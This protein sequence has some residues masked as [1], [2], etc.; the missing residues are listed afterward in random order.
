MTRD[1]LL[2]ALLALVIASMYLYFPLNRG[3]AKYYFMSALDRQIPFV[4]EFIFPYF[5]L[6]PFVGVAL[7]RMFETPYAEAL[8]VALIFGLLAGSL[9][10]YFIKGGIRQPEIRRN[11]VSSRLV[12]WLYRHDDRAH[13]FPSTHVLM[14]LTVAYFCALAFPAYAP[15]IWT[16]GTLVALSTLFVKQ[17]YLADVIG[18]AAYAV[19]A[20]YVSGLILTGPVARTVEMRLNGAHGLV[21]QLVEH[22]HGMEGVRGS[23]PL[24]STGV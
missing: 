9:T 5:G 10:R 8:Y 11:D 21:A 7:I 18:G 22:L 14:A 20:I 16:V 6:F 2:L 1:V 13:T 12:H 4:P 3:R 24:E 15:L 17:H 23:S 19:A